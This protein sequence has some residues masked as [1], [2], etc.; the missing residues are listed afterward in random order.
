M[1]TY[2]LLVLWCIRTRVSFSQNWLRAMY[3]LTPL[4]TATSNGP[5]SV[6]VSPLRGKKSADAT[7]I[8]LS[9][10]V[11]APP[12]YVLD[13]VGRLMSTECLKAMAKST[14]CSWPEKHMMVVFIWNM[15]LARWEWRK[16][17]RVHGNCFCLSTHPPINI[18]FWRTSQLLKRLKRLFFRIR[19]GK[20]SLFDGTFTKLKVDLWSEIWSN[21]SKCHQNKSRE[22]V[23]LHGQTFR[24]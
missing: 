9:R 7:V 20:Y 15:C 4:E 10:V 12:A 1:S 16:H 23:T 2:S 24:V 13:P 11:N 22:H 3:T 18:L 5:S 19:R 17:A 6:P 14:E 8:Q 21:P